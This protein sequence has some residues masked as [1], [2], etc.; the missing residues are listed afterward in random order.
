MH[1]STCTCSGSLVGSL[2]PWSNLRAPTCMY[3]YIL[4]IRIDFPRGSYPKNSEV[5]KCSLST[6]KWS[7]VADTHIAIS[8]TRTLKVLHIQCTCTCT[9]MAGAVFPPG[10]VKYFLSLYRLHFRPKKSANNRS[11]WGN[12]I[13]NSLGNSWLMMLVEFIIWSSKVIFVG[14]LTMVHTC[15]TFVRR[16]GWMPTGIIKSAPLKVGVMLKFMWR[17]VIRVV[18]EQGTWEED[19]I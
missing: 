3:M 1:T 16:A 15:I 7:W 11:P 13:M 18:S 17:G 9:Y 4:H 5:Q 10:G 14:R 6:H 8:I 12:F 19:A 2:K